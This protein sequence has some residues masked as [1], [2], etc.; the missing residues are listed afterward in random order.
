VILADTSVW[1]DYFR[2]DD[3]EMRIYLLNEQVM[4]HPFVVAEL[5]LGSLHDRRKTLAELD[6]L[7][8]VQ[9]AQLDEV[10]SMIEAHSLFSKGIGLTDVHLIA[11]CLM[12]QDVR[13]WTR[14]IRLGDVARAFG[15][16]AIVP[17][18]N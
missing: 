13:L 7:P 9:V 15:V 2:A 16:I 12:T 10:R 4:M 1:I 14:D 3:S 18:P 5:A 8:Q 17:L 11:S 6:R